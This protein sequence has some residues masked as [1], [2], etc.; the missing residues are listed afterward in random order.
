MV[1]ADAIAIFQLGAWH[2]ECPKI[3]KAIFCLHK[4]QTKIIACQ[5]NIAA[6]HIQLAKV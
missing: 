3:T 2:T 5:Y 4:L 1:Q 6:S